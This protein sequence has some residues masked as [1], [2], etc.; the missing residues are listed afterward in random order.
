[1]A[2]CFILG[3]LVAMLLSAPL[4]VLWARRLARQARRLERQ[5]RQA[6]RLAE[7][8]TLTGGLAHEIRNP[9]T[10]LRLNLDLLAEE[11]KQATPDE[12]DDLIRRSLHKLGTLRREA[13]RLDDI[14]EDFLPYAGQHQLQIEPVD[15]NR[16][17]GE[18]VE[19]FNPQAAASHIR[20]RPGLAAEPLT[21]RLDANLFKQAVLNLLINAQQAMSSQAD[22]EHAGGGGDL[23]VRTY[24]ADRFACLEV[25]DTGPGIPPE[26]IERIFDAYYSTKRGGTG[27][28]LPT[29]RRIVEEHHG[30]IDVHSE[31]GKGTS[32]TIRLPLA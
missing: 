26:R 4:A 10:T 13:E 8:A 11:W 3:V 23:I 27:L 9:L 14:L 30:Q 16:V 22:A 15:I 18:L 12:L 25:A 1:M 28:G 24:R 6:Q 31:P 32:F 7:L 29:T 17:V 21:V 19:F 20:L 2:F 5:S